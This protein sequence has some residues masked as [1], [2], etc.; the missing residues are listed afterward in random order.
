MYSHSCSK[1]TSR[2]VLAAAVLLLP[3]AA[4][5]AGDS[6]VNSDPAAGKA[7]YLQTCIAC[8]GANGKG[9][10]PGVIDFTAADGPLSKP[11]EQLAQSIRD[12]VATPGVPLSM[13]AKGGLP[14]LTDEQIQSI[15][16]YLRSEFGSRGGRQK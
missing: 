11:D 6:A 13:P 15:I 3:Q 9:A 16:A 5:M 7:I 8:H 12:G 1:A 10:L 2:A 4:A 14:A